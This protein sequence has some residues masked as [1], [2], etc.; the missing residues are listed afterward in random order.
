MAGAWAGCGL[1][2]NLPRT[3]F[4]ASPSKPA[5]AGNPLTTPRLVRVPFAGSIAKAPML[6]APVLSEYRNLLSAL[7]TIS[8][9]AEPGGLRAT[10]VP[11]MG[12]NAPVLPI[13]NPEIDDDAE[14]DV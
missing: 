10:T 13:A 1:S 5:D 14:L 12:V 6:P 11:G 2:R 7:T 4:A 8:R 3:Q 9:L